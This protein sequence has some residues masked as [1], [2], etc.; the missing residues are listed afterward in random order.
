MTV[1]GSGG[2]PGISSIRELNS[3]GGRCHPHHAA[4]NH[5]NTNSIKSRRKYPGSQSPNSAPRSRVPRPTRRPITRG[6]GSGGRGRGRSS[7]AACQAAVRNQRLVAHPCDARA[8][9]V[10]RTVFQVMDADSGIFGQKC[11]LGIGGGAGP[12]LAE[13]D[14]GVLKHGEARRPCAGI[15]QAQDQVN[16]SGRRPSTA[17]GGDHAGPGQRADGVDDGGVPRQI[18]QE[19]GDARSAAAMPAALRRRKGAARA[20]EGGVSSAA[21]DRLTVQAGGST[22]RCRRGRRGGGVGGIGLRGFNGMIIASIWHRSSAGSL[23]SIRR[24]S[25]GKFLIN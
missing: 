23:G 18:G 22:A 10:S 13:H 2:K 9:Q 6:R 7:P 12:G 16:R 11:Q 17:G 21:S 15:R 5:E 25:S 3:P 19:L 20:G 8:L 24:R 4:H 14:P 1:W